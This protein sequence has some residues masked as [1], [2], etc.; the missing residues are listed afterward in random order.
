MDDDVIRLPSCEGSGLKFEVLK[1]PAAER[2]LPS[3]EGSGLKSI[4]DVNPAE[5]MP[6]SPRVRGVD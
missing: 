1:L 3:C 2:G 4:K 5:I 6:V